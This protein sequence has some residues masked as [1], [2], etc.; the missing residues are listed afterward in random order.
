MRYND[1]PLDHVT[2]E[3]VKELWKAVN[4]FI[5]WNHRKILL[6]GPI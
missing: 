1:Y 3:G 4:Q 6:D 2:P 5:L